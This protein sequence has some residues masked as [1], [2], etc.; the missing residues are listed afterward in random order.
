VAETRSPEKPHDFLKLGTLM[1]LWKLSQD[2]ENRQI[3]RSFDVPMGDVS[4]VVPP[5]YR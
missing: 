5:Q 2:P 1:D 3:V 4:V